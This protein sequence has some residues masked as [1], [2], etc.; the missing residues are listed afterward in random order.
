MTII[1]NTTTGHQVSISPKSANTKSKHKSDQTH[2]V[3][4]DNRI[5]NIETFIQEHK[6]N[7]IAFGKTASK[8]HDNC[9]ANLKEIEY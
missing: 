2:L 1:N 8:E 7:S 6:A 5:S 4:F 3:L 9:N